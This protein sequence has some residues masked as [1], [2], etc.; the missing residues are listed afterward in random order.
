MYG[1]VTVNCVIMNTKIAFKRRGSVFA[2]VLA[3]AWALDRATKIFAVA[4]F[5][6]A[7]PGAGFSLFAV[8]RNYGM[9]FGL[10]SG[11]PAACAAL[12]A[13]GAVLFGAA[14]ARYRRAFITPA[15][16]LLWAGALGNLTDRL[17]HGYVVDWI[18]VVGS[19]NLA[20]VWLGAGVLLSVK[21]LC[22]ARGCE[23]SP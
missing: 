7:M 5:P 2:A 17:I 1:R 19:I 14:C 6:A 3:I 22:R 16:A 21:I 8:Y 12:A 15:G 18:H 23:K 10:L 13:L 9:T 11:N 20:D 4:R